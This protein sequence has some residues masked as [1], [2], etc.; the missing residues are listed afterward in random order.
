MQLCHPELISGSDLFFEQD[1]KTYE[2]Y[3]DFFITII[4]RRVSV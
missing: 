1:S 4:L 3:A 2:V